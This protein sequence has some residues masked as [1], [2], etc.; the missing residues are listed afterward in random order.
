[1]ADFRIRLL[2]SVLVFLAVLSAGA[3]GQT[4]AP[5][6]AVTVAPVQVKDVSPTWEFI[7]RVEAIQ[8]VDLRARVQGFLLQIAFQEGQDVT[9]GQL[10]YVIEPDPYEAAVDAAKA[11]LAKAKATLENADRA[12]ARAQQLS[13]RGFEAQANLDQARAT[14]DSA[15]ADVEAAQAN[16]R[17]AELNL[18]YTRITSPI[19]GRIGHTAVTVGNLVDANS[20]V[21]DTVVQLDPIRVVFSVDDR[22][23]VQAKLQSGGAS[24]EQLNARFVPSLRLAD[25][26][27]YPE[28]GRIAFV[29]NQVDPA[30]GT[31]PVWAEFPNPQHL[32]LPGQFVTIVVKPEETQRK[33]VVPVAAVQEDRDGKF[34]LV[35]GPNDRVEQRRIA[36]DRQVGQD[37]VVESG[38][39]PGESIIVQGMQKVQP[40]GVVKPVPAPA[41]QQASRS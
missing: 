40:G 26:T 16:L 33:P 29:N 41:P 11:Q 5:K 3:L 34:V 21:L 6:P 4:Q 8:S 14:R 10:L 25:G 24:Q 13:Q 23:L 39:Q 12:L 32:L 35:V 22:A 2:T 1:M 36:A 15:A 30:T 20:G 9:A 37:W 7:G 38:L 27:M 19:N 31:V 28:Q 17:T 18:S